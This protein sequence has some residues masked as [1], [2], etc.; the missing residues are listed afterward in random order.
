[1]RPRETFLYYLVDFTNSTPSSPVF[2]YVDQNNN[3]QTTGQL[4]KPLQYAPDGWLN[5][6]I[7]FGRNST[8]YGL[9]RSFSIP[10][11][12]VEDGATIIRKQFYT[13]AGVEQLIELVILKWNPLT[14]IYELYYKGLLDLVSLQDNVAE[15]VTV[16]L[17]EGGALAMLK[18]YGDTQFEIPCDG[19]IAEN[20]LVSMDGLMV[21]DTFQYQFLNL[22]YSLNSKWGQVLGLVYNGNQGDNFGTT[23][24]SPTVES[25]SEPNYYQ[26]SQNYFFSYD[27]AASIT[28]SGSIT[29]K[30]DGGGSEHPGNWFKLTSATSRST[31]PTATDGYGGQLGPYIVSLAPNNGLPVNYSQGVEIPLNW[32]VNYANVG[33]VSTFNFNVTIPLQSNENLFLVGY[34]FTQNTTIL[35]GGF[36]LTFNSSVEQGYIWGT[37]VRNAFKL[38]IQSIN[39]LSATDGV[40]SF[41]FD[42]VSTL[43]DSLPNVVL[44]SGDAV[45]AS[46]DPN[47]T[48]FYNPAQTNLQNPTNK[49]F[50]FIPSYGPVIKTSL[51]DFFKFVNVVFN[52][53]LSNQNNPNGGNEQLF[54]EKK[55]YVF[56]TSEVT[57]DLTQLSEIS[58]LNIKPAT[59]YFF[60]LLKIGYDKQQYDEKEGKYEYNT[61]AQWTSPIRTVNRALE[62]ISPYRTDSYGI[63]YTRANL[64]TDTKS[65]TYNDSDTDVFALNVDVNTTVNA[66]QI[67]EYQPES[68]WPH[69]NNPS[70]DNIK[71]QPGTFNN[72]IPMPTSLNGTFASYNY[73]NPSVFVFSNPDGSPPNNVTFSYTGVING[74]FPGDQCIIYAF[75]NNAIVYEHV[76][77]VA[78]VNEAISGSFTYTATL[79]EGDCLFMKVVT[80]PY[81]TVDITSGEINVG[82][83]WFVAT[84]TGAQTI[85]PGTGWSLTSNSPL[86]YGQ[87]IVFNT[88]GGS[89]RN[90]SVNPNPLT[91]QQ[92]Y[93]MSYG[94]PMFI[95]NDVLNNNNFNWN[96][97][98]NYLYNGSGNI[99]TKLYY[100]PNVNSL[101][102]NCIIDETTADVSGDGN[103]PTLQVTPIN[104]SRNLQLNL[105]DILFLAVSLEHTLLNV[106]ITTP[107]LTHNG[108]NQANVPNACSFTLT[109][110]VQAY[111]L[112]RTQYDAI[113]GVP[114]LLGNVSS[115]SNVPL[116]TGPGAPYNIELFTPRRLLQAWG[117]YIN[118]CLYSVSSN[119]LTFQ[120]LDR[121]RFLSTTAGGVTYTEGPGTQLSPGVVEINTLGSPLFYPFIVTFDTEVPL[122]FAQIAS[123]AA[124]GYIKASYAGVDFYGFPL[125]M[126]QKPAL[127][128]SQSW[129][130][131]LAPPTDI[132]AL[133]NLNYTGLSNIQLMTNDVFVPHLNPVQFVPLGVEPN[134]LYHY[135]NMDND[136]FVNQTTYY[137]EQ[138]NYYCPWQTN[139][140]INLQVYTGG[141]GNVVATVLDCNLNVVY[142]ANF[143]NVTSSPLLA[144]NLLWECSIPLT[145]LAGC[146]WIK[147][148]AG[149]SQEVQFISEGLNI[150][151]DQPETLLFAYSNNYDTQYAIFS[152]GY[153]PTIR[154]DGYIGDFSADA[155]FTSY[156]DQPA[157]LTT[158]N[159]IP[160]RRYSLYIGLDA[161]S[162]DYI[163][164]KVNR[165]MLL[166]TVNIDGVQ[167]SRD[168]DAKIDLTTF[169]GTLKKY[170]KL[171]IREAKNRYGITVS[172]TNTGNEISTNIIYNIDGNAFG[173]NTGTNDVIQ[174]EITD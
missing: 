174:V 20:V 22:N 155:N 146:Y 4:N 34:F 40:Q 38:L 164:D 108:P 19:S 115:S 141:I 101:A 129:E 151:T 26:T 107:V 135:I 60:N 29:V 67:F 95:F 93:G 144:P 85:N 41:D 32:P 109:A 48:R 1:M 18:T 92:T 80:S 90:P 14:D 77:A 46:G 138:R 111:N 66:N 152:D 62:L 124:N 163:I 24:N 118:G 43:L 75:V 87:L 33:Q 150:Q 79:N 54:L 122:S 136:W 8:Y 162:P 76:W 102:S 94:F 28:I 126:K 83:G 73:N 49:F 154:L 147:L 114:T 140:V 110:Q 91:G 7:S 127:N 27:Q 167:Y 72:G 15:G 161:G 69:V 42:D 65:T 9:N 131:L 64:T 133:Q 121:N 88:Q 134:A 12:F 106:E 112:A 148:T 31:P 137:I 98:I 99:T 71:I 139:D 166:S 84:A 74:Q 119:N 117:D 78:S 145:G 82:G 51:N 169:P 25:I 39:Q 86:T 105:G 47:Y 156:E 172:G 96:Y 58:K 165:L 81:C 142:T 158:L 143:T 171:S 55:A 57:L 100:I 104:T 159:G 16:N 130:M 125:E 6:E 103:G 2:F 68:P 153:L 157:D 70:S 10:L 30:D 50:D 168:K 128:E 5:T 52:A 53:S 44:T 63:E 21:Q 120:T 123:G 23:Y 37:S 59:D 89:Y 17:I 45:R 36:N 132:N 116:T 11:K 61:T 56:D 160:F 149:A 170:A 97:L 173:N 13:G 3:V 35:G 113:S